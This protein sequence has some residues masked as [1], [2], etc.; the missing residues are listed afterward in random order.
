MIR[1]L[2]IDFTMGVTYLFDNSSVLR[3]RNTD[4]YQ[5]YLFYIAQSYGIASEQQ[6][7]KIK[8]DDARKDEMDKV[9]VNIIS[10]LAPQ[11]LLG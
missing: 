10:Y 7:Y 8:T 6:S 5:R 1:N 4:E 2:C 3:E 9:T 11:L